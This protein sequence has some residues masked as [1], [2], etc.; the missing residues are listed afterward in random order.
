MKKP[1]IF[2]TFEISLSSVSGIIGGALVQKYFSEVGESWIYFSVAF[3]FVSTLIFSLSQYV[4]SYLRDNMT[5]IRRR[6]SHFIEG[7]WV[8][9]I[10][11]ERLSE[12]PPTKFSLLE[13]YRQDGQLKIRGQSYNDSEG[14]QT[15]NFYSVTSD[16][17]EDSGKL[18][19]IFKF[20]TDEEHSKTSLFGETSLIFG[21]Y[22][23][24]KCPNKYKGVVHS[25]LRDGVRVL[26]V[27][28]DKSQ[29]YNF[30]NPTSRQKVTSTII[31]A[32]L[33]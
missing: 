12:L 25:N 7:H 9:I 30:S 21:R 5:F 14:L 17:D 6:S 28:V 20:S 27:R 26:A 31:E 23:N 22:G 3:L 1:D 32:F 16:Y 13:I 2:S 11:D 33:C 29:S 15:T 8:Q 24:S 18:N 10:E 19:Y 4:T